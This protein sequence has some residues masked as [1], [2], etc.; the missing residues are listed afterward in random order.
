[1][2]SRPSRSR[3]RLES[4]LAEPGIVLESRPIEGGIAL[5]PGFVEDRLTLEPRAH[6]DR[7]APEGGLLE[8]DPG[9]EGR[10][11]EVRLTQEGRPLEPPPTLEGCLLE[12]CRFQDWTIVL[13]G[14]SLQ[15][16]V[17]KLGAEV[18][19][20]CINHA[21]LSD[22][23]ELSLEGGRVPNSGMSQAADGRGESDADAAVTAAGLPLVVG[24]AP[25]H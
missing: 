12:L 21:I 8:P 16:T 1:M 24:H 15:D 23:L 17:K 19:A 4:H 9:L 14:H 5:K 10:P 13:M 18:H 2:A 22:A 20:A 3:S 25:S 7:V 11:P 6:E